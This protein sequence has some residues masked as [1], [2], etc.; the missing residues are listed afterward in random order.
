M[1]FDGRGLYDG[2]LVCQVV[3]TI[4]EIIV[5]YS[6]QWVFT[7]LNTEDID[8]PTSPAPTAVAYAALYGLD[9]ALS[10]GQSATH[11]FVGD[12]INTALADYQDTPQPSLPYVLNYQLLLVS[13]RFI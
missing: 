7:Y 3:P 1:I 11:N 10:Y 4:I 6:G 12:S 9:Q 13:P 5:S 8:P 2:T